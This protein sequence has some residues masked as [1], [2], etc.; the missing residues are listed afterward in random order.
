MFT[1]AT[2]YPKTPLYDL[3]IKEGLVQG[4]YWREFVLGRRV[5]RLPYLIPDAEKWVRRAY[6]SFYFRPHYLLKRLFKIQ[7]WYDL[8]NSIE[9]TKG[10]LCFKMRD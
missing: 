7:D 9:A 10:I 2:P 3:A 1:V 4:D 6:R 8:K 5:D